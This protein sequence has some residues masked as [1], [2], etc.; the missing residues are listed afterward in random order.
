MKQVGYYLP[1]KQYTIAS[2]LGGLEQNMN[3]LWVRLSKQ[4]NTST[5]SDRM[6]YLSGHEIWLDSMNLHE[7]SW[8]LFADENTHQ[9]ESFG[10][11][12]IN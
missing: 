8:I 11:P 9:Q 6:R 12:G 5:L 10:W 2:P 3:N 1:G 4:S 7:T